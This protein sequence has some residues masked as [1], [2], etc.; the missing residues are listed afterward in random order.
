MFKRFMGFYAIL[1]LTLLFVIFLALTVGYAKDKAEE[2]YYRGLYD[3]CSQLSHQRLACLQGAA[4]AKMFGYYE[5]P[6]QGWL[7]P[8]QAPE[9][10]KPAPTPKPT[11][12][13]VY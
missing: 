1:F 8:L 5:S 3:G 12:Q 11:L 2:E 6:S 13:E 4:N 10:P 9:V 7:W